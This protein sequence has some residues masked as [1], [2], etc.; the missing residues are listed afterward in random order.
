MADILNS[1]LT[2][3]ADFAGSI[4]GS[5]PE[6]AQVPTDETKEVTQ[7]T[8]ATP[9]KEETPKA[10]TKKPE[11]KVEPKAEKKVKA[12]KEEASKVVEAITKEVSSE[13]IKEKSN[14]STP[15]DK[16]PINPHFQD[17]V[18]ADAPEGDDSEKGISSWKEI[19]NEMKKA[20]EER[21]RLKAELEATKEQVGKYEGETIKSLQEELESYKTR[22]AELGRELKTANFE[23]SPEYVEQIK[24]PLAGLQGDLQ[25]IAE[26]NDADFSKLWQA[27]TEPDVR[28]RT[29]SLEDLTGDFKRME[30]LSIVKIADKYHELAQYHQ[31]FQSE[32]ESLA[33]AENARKA[34]AEQEFIEN[35]LR[36]QKAFT[37]KTWTSLEDRYNFLQEVDGQD[38][39]NSH[40]RNAKKS[41]SET[42]LDRLSVEDRSAI[43]ARAAVVPFLESAISHYSA[44]LEK[45]VTQKDAKIKELQAQVDGFVKATPSLG[46]S[47]EAEV[48]TEDEDPDVFTNFGRAIL[49]R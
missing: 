34:Q 5:K 14:E 1:A 40:I 26:A 45:T 29:D 31:R 10:E 20:R 6:S 2:G 36:L 22:M 15:E 32:A 48:D 24:K 18:V 7:E 8:Q 4:F 12:T 21:D 25:A 23:R 46:G 11:P 16:L 9:D 49:G 28:K 19:K 39:W 47:T 33:E 42:N 38:E 30:Q 35:D 13:K 27:I 41:A 3:D 17:K 43:L 44:Q 37:A